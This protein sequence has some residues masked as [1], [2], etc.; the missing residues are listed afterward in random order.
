VAQLESLQAVAGDADAAGIIAFQVAM[1]EDDAC[2]HPRLR[3]SMRARPSR[4]HGG[5]S[6]RRNSPDTRRRRIPISVRAASI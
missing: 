3:Q 4:R 2:A 6:W 5:R 1:L